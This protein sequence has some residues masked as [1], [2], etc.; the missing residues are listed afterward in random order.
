MYTST[1]LGHLHNQRFGAFTQSGAWTFTHQGFGTL[2]FHG[3][4]IFSSRVYASSY[5]GIHTSKRVG[6]L[7]P[8]MLGVYTSRAWAFTYRRVLAI[9]ISTGSRHLHTEV[10]G[11]Y[12]SWGLGPY[13]FK[14]V[15]HL[16]IHRCWTFAHPR[17]WHI[18]TCIHRVR[19]F[20]RQHGH[21]AAFVAAVYQASCWHEFQ[22]PVYR[23]STKHYSPGGT[24]R[25]E[26]WSL[27]MRV[28][29]TLLSRRQT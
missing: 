19:V 22:M 26:T 8:G 17:T 13:T 27:L 1:D 18:Y 28:Q 20:T 5:L 24:R 21:T 7:H 10:L 25:E 16:H 6:H 12:T 2:H 4:S 29:N 23:P 9:Y 15:G 14:D 3:L 11:V